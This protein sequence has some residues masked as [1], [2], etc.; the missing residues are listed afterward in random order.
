MT[1]TRD[2]KTMRRYSELSR[3]ETSLCQETPYNYYTAGTGTG[4]LVKKGNIDVFKINLTQF[5]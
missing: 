3:S 4:A 2:I 1:Q 5:N